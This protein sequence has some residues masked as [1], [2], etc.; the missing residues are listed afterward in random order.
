MDYMIKDKLKVAVSSRALF[1]LEKENE[2][3]QTMG[4]TAYEA[5][6]IRH[7]NDILM[8]GAAF[9]IVRALLNLGQDVEVIIISKNTADISLRIFNSIQAH[10]LSITRGFFTEGESIIGYLKS[11]DVDLYLTANN[12][13]AYEAIQNGISAAT[14]VIPAAYGISESSGLRIAFD[15]DA[16]LFSGDAEAVFTAGGVNAFN[17]AEREQENIPMLEGPMAKFLKAL[18]RIQNQ[19]QVTT[20]L[21]TSRCAPAH[22]RAIK[23]LRA[24]GIKVNQAFFLGGMDK[25]YILRE[26]RPQIFFDDQHVHT[27]RAS[28]V[29]PSGTVPRHKEKQGTDNSQKTDET[30]RGGFDCATGRV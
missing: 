16:V 4:K 10:G 22:A 8:P 29:V 7:E 27:Q 3:F 18:S 15:G 2:I 1:Q 28:C 12:M 23:T 20:A 5:Y 11:L 13:A 21:V 14:M 19:G 17:C 6:Q 26:F 24:W 25:T 30:D 9:P